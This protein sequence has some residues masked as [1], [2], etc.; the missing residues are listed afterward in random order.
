MMKSFSALL[1]RGHCLPLLVAV[2]LLSLSSLGCSVRVS[3]S[4]KSAGDARSKSGGSAKA[5]GSANGSAQ[6]SASRTKGDGSQSKVSV[7]LRGSSSFRFV[8][9]PRTKLVA[10]ST[11]GDS[12]SG[13]ALVRGGSSGRLSG[14]ASG[15]ASVAGAANGQSKGSSSQ[16]EKKAS[17]SSKGATKA[18]TND[19]EKTEKKKKSTSSGSAQVKNKAREKSSGSA[20]V[21]SK[22]RDEQSRLV[23]SGQEQKGSDQKPKNSAKESKKDKPKKEQVSE[24]PKTDSPKKDAPKTEEPAQDPT[25]EEPAAVEVIEPPEAPPE[26]VFGYETPV[27]GC[28]EGIVYPLARQTRRLPANFGALT[29][30]SVVYAC[31]WDIPTRDWGAGFPGVEDRFEWFA[32]EYKGSFAVEAAGTYKF[33]LASDDGAKLFIDGKLVINND[34]VHAPVTKRGQIELAEGDHDMVLQYFQGPRYHINLQLFAT[35]PGGEEGI[36]SVR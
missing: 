31:E 25:P 27:R 4:A 1:K 14:K 11:K 34:G 36:F 9:K 12:F 2:A 22:K 20:Q 3:G 26:N 29:G 8:T 13:T 17:A 10:R 28:F 35:P 18:A 7:K 5:G 6:K 21:E 33:R 16:S 15:R 24:R 32:I 23:A 19:A 30:I